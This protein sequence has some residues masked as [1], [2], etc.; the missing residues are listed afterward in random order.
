MSRV[1]D[2]NLALSV[3]DGVVARTAQQAASGQKES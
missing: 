3:L 1:R 2:N